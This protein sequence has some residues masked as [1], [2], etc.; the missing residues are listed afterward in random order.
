MAFS[1]FMCRDILYDNRRCAQR[2]SCAIKEELGPRLV[3]LAGN[4]DNALVWAGENQSRESQ[5]RGR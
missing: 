2:Q 1:C 5:R 3:K 4:V